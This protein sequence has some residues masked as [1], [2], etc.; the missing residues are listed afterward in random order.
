MIL[1]KSNKVIV[2]G[3]TGRQGTFWT[4]KM[5]AYGTQIVAGV[6]PK[7][8]G[9]RHCDVPIFGSTA[10]A[11]RET[12]ADSAVMFIPPVSAREAALSAI[13]A[14]IEVLV[15]LTEH[16][17]AQDV[18][19]LL[20]AAVRRGTRII[21]PNTAGLVTPGECFAGIMPAF[22]P[23]VFK[24][25]PIGVISRSGSLGTLVCLELTQS[26][27][28]QSAFIGIGGDPMLGTTTRD[29]LAVLDRDL[30]TG[31]VVNCRRDRRHYGRGRRAIRQDNAQAGSS[32]DRRR[33]FAARQ[34][35][36]PRGRHR[37]RKSR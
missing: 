1:R 23:S 29:A 27:L 34:E 19:A 32:L 36:G 5:L 11:V 24:P 14:G 37:D 35:D 13:E 15:V 18:M 16:I 22:V 4:E 9:E 6:H 20:A 7:R 25:G 10:E 26:G 28:G 3:I 17:P 21:G 30:A 12:G 8:A 33:C 2:L 31:A